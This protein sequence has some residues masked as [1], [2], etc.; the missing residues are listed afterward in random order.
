MNSGT[1][2]EKDGTTPESG[3]KM[4]R[5]REEEKKKEGERTVCRKEGE[6]TKTSL[7]LEVKEKC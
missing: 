2:K 3:Q 7:S 5:R 6:K 1:V 4:R